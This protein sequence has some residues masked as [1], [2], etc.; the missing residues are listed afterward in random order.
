MSKFISV[1]NNFNLDVKHHTDNQHG[2]EDVPPMIVNPG[3][4]TLVQ[5]PIK[6][7]LLLGTID[8]DG[9]VVI[10][11]ILLYQVTAEVDFAD[12][13]ILVSRHGVRVQP[14]D[15]VIQIFRGP[16]EVAGRNHGELE[17]TRILRGPLAEIT[18]GDDF[19]DECF[20]CFHC[21]NS[22]SGFY[23]MSS[24]RE[25]FLEFILNHPADHTGKGLPALSAP[26][27]AAMT[28]EA[29]LATLLVHLQFYDVCHKL[30]F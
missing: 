28:V 5:K 6:I 22:L 4:Q 23:R 13:T 9:S 21:G 8:D 26:Q 27:V 10:H 1:V 18:D 17:V 19:G 29:T 3:K 12:H 15:G 14:V 30:N 2:S 20:L 24:L 7:G 25:L 16:P 11:K